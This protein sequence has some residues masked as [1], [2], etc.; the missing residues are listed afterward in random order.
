MPTGRVI[1]CNVL[2]TSLSESTFKKGDCRRETLSAVFSVSSNTA[3]P[4]LLAKS[5]RTMVS[6]SVSACALPEKNNQ[7]ATASPMTSIVAPVTAAHRVDLR[8]GFNPASSAAT[9]ARPESE[10]RFS[11]CKS[12]RISAALWYRSF[13]SFSRALLMTSSS[14]AEMSGFSRT[15]A[16]G[17]RFRIASVIT[18]EVSPRKG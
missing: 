18:P 11:R 3:S 10:S 16:T 8:A 14:F 1:C 4:V 9:A 6:F 15:G 13:L 17:L 5:A 7:P 2:A 12:V